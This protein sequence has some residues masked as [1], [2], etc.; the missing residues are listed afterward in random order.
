[1]CYVEAVEYHEGSPNKNWWAI[2]ISIFNNSVFPKVELTFLVSYM[3]TFL[4]LLYIWLSLILVF[5]FLFSGL[6]PISSYILREKYNSRY[7][8]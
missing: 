1:M 7:W 3:S 6:L 2:K 8:K 5:L 4:S